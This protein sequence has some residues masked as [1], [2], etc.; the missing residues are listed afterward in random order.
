MGSSVS[1]SSAHS[2]L[3]HLNIPLIDCRRDVDA[4]RAREK[5]RFAEEMRFRGKLATLS[6]QAKLTE[7]E[8]EM[9]VALIDR[10]PDSLSDTDFGKLCSAIPKDSIA[11]IAWDAWRDGTRAVVLLEA[12][13]FGAAI[14]L[15]YA[16]GE[17]LGRLK[18]RNISG[19]G[20]RKKLNGKRVDRA[21]DEAFIGYRNKFPNAGSR[22]DEI[23]AETHDNSGVIAG[24]SNRHTQQNNISRWKKSNGINTKATASQLN[25]IAAGIADRIRRSKVLACKY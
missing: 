7:L 11:R 9:N 17:N 24:I 14:G 21:L 22:F 1:K 23:I 4:A 13:D 18:E 20:P 2:L 8:Q 10:P 25:Q 19:S 12:G 15:V 16:F 6:L 5:E 3:T